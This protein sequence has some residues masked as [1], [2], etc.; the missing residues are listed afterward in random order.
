[1]PFFTSTGFVAARLD[2]TECVGNGRWF[3]L[4]VSFTG[5]AKTLRATVHHSSPI[6]VKRNILASTL[7][8]IQYFR[9]RISAALRWIFWCSAMHF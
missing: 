2:Y 6:Y 4:P 3:E 9:S 7:I 5:L 1:V 8:P